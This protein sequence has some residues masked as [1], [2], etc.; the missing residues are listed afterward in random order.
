MRIKRL[1]GMFTIAN[2]VEIGKIKKI[3]DAGYKS[4]ICNRPDGE[5]QDKS[6]PDFSVVATQAHKLGLKAVYIPVPLTGADAET[7]AAFAEAVQSLPKPILA[8]CRSGTRSG[9]LWSAF[10]MQHPDLAPEMTRQAIGAAPAR[11]DVTPDHM[12]NQMQKGRR[13]SM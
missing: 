13:R 9:T 1:N 8:Y 5:A 6:Q 11:G 7:Q 3:A 2:Q 4:I 10:Q 12:E